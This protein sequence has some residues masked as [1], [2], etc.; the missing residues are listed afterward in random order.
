M[1]CLD[2]GNGLA[3]G[4]EL[5]HV[6]LGHSFDSGDEVEGSGEGREILDSGGST[7][8]EVFPVG[9][10]DLGISQSQEDVSELYLLWILACLTHDLVQDHSQLECLVGSS[11]LI[12]EF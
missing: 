9:H 8:H 2:G 7:G 6:V 5:S 4:L 3:T 11:P 1:N 12:R 10:C